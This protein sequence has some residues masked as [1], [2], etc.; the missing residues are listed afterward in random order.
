M[1]PTPPRGMTVAVAMTVPP[2][3]PPPR[4]SPTRGRGHEDV[5][6]G[7]GSSELPDP[8][9]RGGRG[10]EDVAPGDGSSELPGPPPQ[11]GRGTRSAPGGTVTVTSM[12][13]AVTPACSLYRSHAAFSSMVVREPRVVG[14]KSHK[15]G[16]RGLGGKGAQ[17]VP[18]SS[19]VADRA[20]PSPAPCD[21][22]IQRNRRLRS[23]PVFAADDRRHV[24]YRQHR[25]LYCGGFLP[26]RRRRAAQT[27]WRWPGPTR[28]RHAPWGACLSLEPPSPVTGPS[29]EVRD[30]NNDDLGICHRED[31]GVRKSS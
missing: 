18:I 2:T 4:P 15:R 13:G 25:T 23:M 10:H 12:R 27:A 29:T 8:P 22:L 7:D 14:L 31:D 28:F 6:P 30:G 19:A 24:R 20:L 17:S 1:A 9:P 26:L 5:A 21:S 16:K 11:G 3:P